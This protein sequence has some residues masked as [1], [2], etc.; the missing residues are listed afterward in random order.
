MIRLSI[1]G[2]ALAAFAWNAPAASAKGII[3]INTGEGITL[4]GDA[5]F[6]AG[7]NPP[8]EAKT[9]TQVGYV[10]SRFGIF[11]VDLWRWDGAYCLYDG[12]DDGFRIPPE[13]AA[14]LLG[15]PESE[16]PK[17]FWYRFPGGIV[18]GAVI[19]LAIIIGQV[20]KHRKQKEVA[21]LTTN[22]D[23]QNA[24]ALFHAELAKPAEEP[25]A[26][27]WKSTRNDPTLEEKTATAFRHA[28]DYLYSVGI[29]EKTARENLAVMVGYKLPDQE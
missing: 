23:Y 20:S 16:L 2:I 19:V 27:E 13:I 5:K 9:C 14:E 22:P 18:V 28:V 21:S 6:P 26:D 12:K 17:P 15:V 29:P 3:I 8:A 4:V 24:V 7:V 1:L 25:K 11:W 10:Y